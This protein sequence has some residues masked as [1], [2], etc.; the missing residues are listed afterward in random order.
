M[1]ETKHCEQCGYFLIDD[2]EGGIVENG[3]LCGDCE[4]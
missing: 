2:P 1:T 3:P 4:G